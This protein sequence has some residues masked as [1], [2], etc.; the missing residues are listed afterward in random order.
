[1]LHKLLEK[2]ESLGLGAFTG[3]LF[4]GL[5]GSVSVSPYVGDSVHVVV[6]GCVL[7]SWCPVHEGGGALKAHSLNPT[8]SIDT[9]HS[10]SHKG[11][12]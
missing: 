8:P 3:V 5:S 2:D 4:N 7:M 1:M 12:F 6:G 10:Y 11:L 9:P